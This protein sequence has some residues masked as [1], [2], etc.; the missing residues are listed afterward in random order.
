[1]DFL[2]SADIYDQDGN[3]YDSY[4]PYQVTKGVYAFDVLIPSTDTE[5]GYIFNDVWSNISINGVSRPDITLDVELRDAMQYYNI[6]SSDSLPK[7]VA[8]SIGGLQNKEKIK[9]GDIRKVIV[10]ARIPYTVEQ[11]Q[12]ISGLQYRLWVSEG[13]S[14]LTVIDFQPVEMANNYYYFLL[15]TASLIPNTYYL[16]VLATS[17]LEVTTIKNVLQFEIIN[18]VELRKGQ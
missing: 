11:T 18:Q 6:G 17:N 14:E 9:R 16:D 3:L 13:S 8:V 15:D 10:S 4:V 5:S 12:S 1:L 2:P 7:K